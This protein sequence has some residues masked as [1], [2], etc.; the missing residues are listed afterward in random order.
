IVGK[1]ALG[2]LRVAVDREGDALSEKCLLRFRLMVAKLGHGGCQEILIKR[3]TMR[4]R[5]SG[6]IE[7]LVVRGVKE[8][9]GEHRAGWFRR[10]GSD[11]SHGRPLPEQ[12][13]IP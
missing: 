3:L 6:T 7:H 1:D 5:L 13:A 2:A 12:N 8:V 11:R 4:A 9:I 10:G